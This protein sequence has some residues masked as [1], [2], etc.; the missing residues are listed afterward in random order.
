MDCVS[1]YLEYD[2]WLDNNFSHVGIMFYYQPSKL[3]AEFGFCVHIMVACI[4][5]R[6]RYAL[7]DNILFSPCIINYLYYWLGI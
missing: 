4:T 7:I 6:I 1:V 5:F 3:V 2:L